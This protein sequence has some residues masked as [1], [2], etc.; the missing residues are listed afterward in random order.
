MGPVEGSGCLWVLV[1]HWCL[2]KA[3]S[4]PCR[5]YS[6]RCGLSPPDMVAL[7]CRETVEQRED[8]PACPT[9]AF[10]TL[11]GGVCPVPSRSVFP[12]GVPRVWID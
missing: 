11:G 7:L 3:W 8:R 12:G 6:G 4:V 5:S 1:W 10:L 2:G 9:W